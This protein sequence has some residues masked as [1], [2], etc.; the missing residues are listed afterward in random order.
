MQ[1][2]ATLSSIYRYIKGVEILTSVLYHHSPR[3]R[4]S[5]DNLIEEWS[6]KESVVFHLRLEGRSFWKEVFPLFFKYY[7]NFPRYLRYRAARDRTYRFKS[8]FEDIVASSDAVFTMLN[9]DDT[10]FYRESEVPGEILRLINDMPFDVSYRMYVGKNQEDCPKNLTNYKGML[11]WD[12]ADPS[13]YRH[14]S[15]PFANDASIYSTNGLLHTMRKIYYYSPSSLEAY[16][17]DY[18]RRY[19]IFGR[20]YSPI[21]SSAITLPLNAVSKECSE[22]YGG[23]SP[24]RLCALYEKGFRMY[25]SYEKTIDT[26]PYKPK[27]IAL[28]RGDETLIIRSEPDVL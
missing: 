19:N 10:L 16:V 9:P 26:S 25:F 18:C 6:E 7:R 14:W 3:H 17:C 13:M 24:E 11:K 15:Y 2:D 28:K 23:Y 20:G 12:Y 21:C 1:L 22:D 27:S 4:K 5:Y 8:Q